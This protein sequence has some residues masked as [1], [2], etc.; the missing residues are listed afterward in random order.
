MKSLTKAEEQVMQVIWKLQSGLLMEIVE[1]MPEPQP[2]KNTVATILKTL[3]EK[4]FVRIEI[5]GRIHRYHFAV[6][7]DEYSKSTLTKVAKGYFS[8]SYTDVVSF[9]VEKKKLSVSDLEL[10]LKE[11]K[12]EKK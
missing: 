9:L 3:V 1:K 4:G 11:L 12:K 6:S 7:K 2:H 8:G 5:L 10:L